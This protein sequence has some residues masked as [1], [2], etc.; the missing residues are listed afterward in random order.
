M[1]VPPNHPTSD[2]FSIETGDLGIPQDFEKKNTSETRHWDEV[3]RMS[4]K[5]Q[6]LGFLGSVGFGG[7]YHPKR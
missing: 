1:S 2:Y 4:F 5:E 7:F 6:A 3:G